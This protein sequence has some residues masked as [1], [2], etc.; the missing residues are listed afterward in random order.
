MYIYSSNL[1]LKEKIMISFIVCAFNEEDNIE[2]TVVSIREAIETSGFS[3]NYEVVIINDGSK[4]KTKEVI[5][6]LKKNLLTSH[7]Y[8]IIKTWVMVNHL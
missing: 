4:D 5:L 8:K 1:F 2:D 6:S 7:I 3:E